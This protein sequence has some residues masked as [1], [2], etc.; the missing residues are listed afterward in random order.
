MVE[1]R[2]LTL[3]RASDRE[4]SV[5]ATGVGRACVV[6]ALGLIGFAIAVVAVA[7]FNHDVPDQLTDRWKHYPEFVPYFFAS[8]VATWGAVAAAV[9]GTLSQKPSRNRYWLVAFAVG[10]AVAHGMW[11]AQLRY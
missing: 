6:L 3:N 7:Y 8:R 2:G 1:D 4:P 5:V 9:L 11:E 10:T